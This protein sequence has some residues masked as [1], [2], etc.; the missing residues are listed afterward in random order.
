MKRGTGKA[1]VLGHRGS[2]RF[3]PENTL[4]SFEAALRAGADGVE[5]D[6]QLTQDEVLVVHHDP[7]VRG[8]PIARMGLEQFRAL[9]PAAPTFAETLAFFES[10]PNAYINIELKVPRD[11]GRAELGA[12]R[13]PLPDGRAEL[14]VVRLSAWNAPTKERTWVSSFSPAAL[15]ELTRLNVGVPLALLAANEADLIA[16]E[17][18]PVDAVHPQWPLVTRDGI[19][20]WKRMGLAV[21]VWT[22]NTVEEANRLLALGVDGLIGDD[23][24]LLLRARDATR[25]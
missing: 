20:A 1:L 21:H 24:A 7:T 4:A 16:L 25:G 15:A 11:P 12:S 22:V 14:L 19:D 13:S 3:E 9:A 6:L 23:P 5:L 18:L 10:W 8:R 2:P 17:D